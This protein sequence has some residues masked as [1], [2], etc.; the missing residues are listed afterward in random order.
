VAIDVEFWYMEDARYVTEL[1]NRHKARVPVRVIVDQRANVKYDNNA[2]ILQLLRDAGIP[3]REKFGGDILHFKTMLFHGQNMVEFSKAN[4]GAWS[5]A[6]AEPNVNYDDEAIFF[7]NDNDLTNS[8]RR[9]FDDHWTNTVQF[10]DFA[11]VIGPPLRHYPDYEIHSSMNFPPLEDFGAR[12]VSR[13]NAERQRIDAI[14]FRINDDRQAD[15]M[16]N[17]VARGVVVRL[18]SEPDEYRDPKRPWH[19]K[20]VDR[21]WMGGVQVKHRQHQGL[22]HQ[23]S[24]VMHGLGEVIFGSSNWT[25]ASAW[26]QDEHN[27]FYNPS[28]GK[29][30]FF[31][32]FADQF[33][34][35]WNDTTNYV[36]FQPLPPGP[37]TNLAPQNFASGQSAT[38]TLRWDGGPF[39]H[40][41]DI[42]LGTNPV[43]PLLAAHLKLGSPKEGEQEAYTV[44][45]LMPGTTY[46]WRIVGKTWANL[47]KSGPTWSFTT[48]GAPPGGSGLT[49]Y[50][51]TPATVPG[52]FEAENFDLGGQYI[53][54]YDETGGN[55]GG[56]HRP[57]E[58]VDIQPTTDAGGGYNVGWT[59]AGEWLKYTVAIAATSTYKFEAR[60]ANPATGGAFR[61]EVDGVDLFGPIAVPNTS[62][63]QT[64][65]T[66]TTAAVPLTAG[67]RVVRIVFASSGNST[68]VGNYNWFRFV[69]STSHGGSAVV[70]P[71]IVQVENYD[72]GGQGIGYQDSNAGNTGNV[73]RS[74]DVDIGSTG[75]PANGGYYVGWT[76]VGEW[77]KYT[78]NVTETRS[79]VAKVRVANVGSGATFRID[80]DGVDRTG[81]IA[82]PNTGGWDAWQTVPISLNGV[83]SEGSHVIRLVMLTK[84]AENAGVGNYGYLLFE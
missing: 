57:A 17:A 81:P 62:G 20:H 68:G 32:W 63:W 8:F 16:I 22:T 12:S 26:T 7:T 2:T 1:V 83:L 67:Q 13:Y 70:L 4:Y 5:L 19:S 42:Y 10:R 73:Y 3:M 46:Y 14:S 40:L 41:Y 39:A 71:G 18:L 52:T 50:G 74:D 75:D 78:V 77:L 76:R 48:A 59:K 64:W 9:R 21:M 47:T 35:K 6:P 79:Y 49:P 53:A 36:P 55:S 38:V 61:V 15:A 27:Y 29:P 82:L 23:A 43:P 60:V 51:G 37:L 45:G 34:R 72:V 28:L 25:Y 54:Y 11:N 80:V 30:W 65:Q 84:N 69:E 58:G 24:V 44:S 56:V 33:E 31:Q 66:V